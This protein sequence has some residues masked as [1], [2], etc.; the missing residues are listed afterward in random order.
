M[1]SP[2]KR[3]A[4]EMGLPVIEDKPTSPEFSRRLSSFS[5]IW[6]LLWHMVICL[7]K[8]LDAIAGGWYNLHFSLLPLW[9]GAAPVQRSI[10]AG[11]TVTGASVFRI[12][13]GLDDGPLLGQVSVSIGE[14]ETSGELLQRLSHDG[15]L[16]LRSC[17]RLDIG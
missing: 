3:V 17:L 16:L 11:D 7:S 8:A 14:H 12:G 10:W 4:L 9:R 13:P 1:P 5:Q 15:A 6:Q 2:V